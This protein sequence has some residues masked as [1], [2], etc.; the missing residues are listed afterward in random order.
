M[1][2]D[3]ALSGE[4][5]QTPATPK[6]VAYSYVRFSTAKQELGDSLRR[7]VEMA[8]AYCDKHGLELHED[9]YRDLGVS[10]FKRANVQKGALA[11]FIEA[12]RTGK[13]TAGSY[14]VIEQFDRLSRDDVDFA[15][16]LLLDLVHAGIK[17][18]TLVD[19]KVW[20]KDSVKDIGN[21]I[22]AI[23]FMS[24]ANNESAMKAERLSHVWH[25]KKSKAGTPGGKLVTSEGP[26]WL[27]ANEDKTAWE[28]LEDK[29]ESVRKVFA[30][31]ISGYGVVSTVNLANKEKWP[32]PGK[33]DTWHTSLV[34]RLLKSRA[35][36]GEYQ[37]CKYDP[38]GK[39]VPV[40]DPIQ[41]YY[42]VIVDEQTFLRAQA[43]ADR[44]GAFPGRR[45]AS[46]RNWLQGLLKC[47]CGQSFV[48]KNKDSKAQPEYAR[49][50]CTARNRGVTQCPGASASELENA[51][52]HVVSH[53]APQYF[54]GTAR[55]ETLKAR[56][57]VLEVDLSA[58]KQ[59]RD[60]FVEA[61]GASNA[62]IPA[63]M[64]R[65]ADAE[66]EAAEREQEMRAARAELADLEGDSDTVFANIVKAIKSV[67]SLDARAAL[68]EDLSRVIEK[69]VVHQ[70][71]GFIRVFLRGGDTPVVQPLR[72]DAALPGLTFTK[73]LETGDSSAQ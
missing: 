16:K 32:V 70:A 53:V 69:V 67:D 6:P 66:K 30:R 33:G 42:P 28:V 41:N 43:V 14:L 35:V 27:R 54:E 7:Q 65:L 37:P 47:T 1:H 44:K 38:D 73:V 51:V 68:R 40:G 49:Y 19:G 21:L 39:R 17:L 11:S 5:T 45:D 72:M 3:D 25:Q 12:V 55:M 60:R 57:E 63:L 18:V 2:I 34:G 15:L 29:A 62:P 46:L 52:I 48:R 23:V 20:D 24:R 8:R 59:K 10:A 64:Q 50:Y 71:E 13:V 61:I 56:I 9:S 58:A 36:L 31:K 22:L 4:E 26:K